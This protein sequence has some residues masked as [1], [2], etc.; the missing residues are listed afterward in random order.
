MVYL[1]HGGRSVNM[2]TTIDLTAPFG[3]FFIA[4]DLTNGS[5]LIDVNLDQ[6]F[7]LLRIF[8]CHQHHVKLKVVLAWCQVA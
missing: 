6:A 3:R 7:F 1:C 5:W 8:L 4:W 2:M